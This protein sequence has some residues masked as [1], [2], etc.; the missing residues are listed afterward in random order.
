[1]ADPTGSPGSLGRI[2]TSTE[3]LAAFA[4]QAQNGCRENCQGEEVSACEDIFARL[5]QSTV[6]Y[7]GNVKASQASMSPAPS[8]SS[9]GGMGGLGTLLLGTAAGGV[10]GYMLADGNGGDDDGSEDDSTEEDCE[11]NEA[12]ECYD[13]S[14]SY[15]ETSDGREEVEESEEEE[16]SNE[17]GELVMTAFADALTDTSSSTSS[18]SKASVNAELSNAAEPSVD[19]TQQ[20]QSAAFSCIHDS[21]CEGIFAAVERVFQVCV[22]LTSCKNHYN[23]VKSVHGD[24]ELLKQN[25]KTDIQQVGRAADQL[26]NEKIQ[27]IGLPLESWELFLAGNL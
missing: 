10:A 18:E 13:S 2:G 6:R 4:G 8:K 14:E 1:M 26:F 17:S 19:S 22:D 3:A 24:I 15:V 7:G 12:G 11:L 27:G 25:P 5:A 16:S 9:G 20:S 23:E 21:Q